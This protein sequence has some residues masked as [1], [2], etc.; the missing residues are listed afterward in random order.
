MT[1]WSW[2]RHEDFQPRVARR[3]SGRISDNAHDAEAIHAQERYGARL[4]AGPP[5]AGDVP[6]WLTLSPKLFGKG[7]RLFDGIDTRK[8]QLQ[9]EGATHSPLVTHLHYAVKQR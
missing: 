3:Q 8:V 5:R 9:L 7:L 2:R 1:S 6:A 4:Q